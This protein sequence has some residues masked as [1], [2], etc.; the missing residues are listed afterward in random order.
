M[1]Y[2]LV[3]SRFS[4]GPSREGG[5]GIGLVLTGAIINDPLNLIHSIFTALSLSVERN[6]ESS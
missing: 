5:R 1:K 6:R 3:F 2:S 4:G